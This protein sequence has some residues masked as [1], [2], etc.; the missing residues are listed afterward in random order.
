[1]IREVRSSVLTYEPALYPYLLS[2]GRMKRRENEAAHNGSQ[3]RGLVAS[4]KYQ[5]NYKM[6]HHAFDHIVRAM[7]SELL[8]LHIFLVGGFMVMSFGIPFLT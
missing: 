5:T 3:Q 7:A 8:L 4:L 1:M 6:W 2:Y